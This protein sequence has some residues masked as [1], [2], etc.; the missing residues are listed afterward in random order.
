MKRII[1]LLTVLSVLFVAPACERHNKDSLPKK[2]E[3]GQGH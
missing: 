2:H 3:P 1:S